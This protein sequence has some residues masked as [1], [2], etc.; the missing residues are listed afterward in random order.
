MCNVVQTITNV[1]TCY[2]LQKPVAL[3]FK[4]QINNAVSPDHN[5]DGKS[6]TYIKPYPIKYLSFLCGFYVKQYL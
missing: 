2:I 3:L 1:N 4:Q 5:L 6:H